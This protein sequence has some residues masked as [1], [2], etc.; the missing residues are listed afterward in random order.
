MTKKAPFFDLDGSLVGMKLEE[1]V[2]GYLQTISASMAPY[3]FESKTLVQTIYR[4]MAAMNHHDPALTNEEAFLNVMKEQYGPEVVEKMP[5]F[6]DY[7]HTDFN[8]NQQHCPKIPLAHEVIEK[9][10]EKGLM[11]ILATNPVFPRIAI[12]RRLAWGGL[13]PE[14]FAWITSYENSHFCKPD[15][16]YYMEI[17][18]RFGLKPEEILMVGNDL[19]EDYGA[20]AAGMDLFVL[21]E[22]LIEN[23]T[24]SSLLDSFP[25]GSMADLLAYVDQL[26][27]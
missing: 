19:N 21:T 6:E 23:K 22:Y 14:E 24:S 8:L 27:V 10:K 15:P 5:Y 12:E 7:Y 3:G 2:Q 17:A 11:T 1:F 13:K 26:E 20:V 4:G 16:R 18:D 25:H 9:A